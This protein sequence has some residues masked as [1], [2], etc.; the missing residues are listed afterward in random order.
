MKKIYYLS[1][2]DTCKRILKELPKIESFELQE[3]KKNPVTAEQLQEMYIKTESY[4]KL[5]NKRAQLYKSRGLKDQNLHEEDFK[6]LI[7]EH[8]TFLS[9]PVIFV[10]DQI[11]VGNSKK[12]IE[13]A[14]IAV[15]K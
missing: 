4:E 3:I 10:E 11:F 14:I 5:F 6:N 12:V 1:T 13:E 9:R 8:Y 2:C 7:E 15:S